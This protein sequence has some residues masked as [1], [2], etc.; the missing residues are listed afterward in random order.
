MREYLE[1]YRHE[2]E[3]KE[4][5]KDRNKVSIGALVSPYDYSMNCWLQVL[6]SERPLQTLDF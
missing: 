6:E 2:Y 3:V 4:C 5:Y 1:R